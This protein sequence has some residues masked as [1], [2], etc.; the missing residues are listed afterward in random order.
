M[1]KPKRH[2]TNARQMI[3]HWENADGKIWAMQ[4]R[5]KGDIGEI[6]LS[7]PYETIPEN[8]SVRNK[9][10]KDDIEKWMAN[11][12]E[13]PMASLWSKMNED[14]IKGISNDDRRIVARYILVQSIRTAGMKAIFNRLIEEQIEEHTDAHG[15][16]MPLY[17]IY[18]SGDREGAWFDYYERAEMNWSDDG[19]A[20]QDLL[21]PTDA[22]ERESR[23]L[24]NSTWI[25]WR[26]DGINEFITSDEPVLFERGALHGIGNYEVSLMAIDPMRMLMICRKGNGYNY[27]EMMRHDDVHHFNL[28]IC[29]QSNQIIARE[30]NVLALYSSAMQ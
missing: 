18:H 2:H 11:E 22:F 27:L 21:G 23:V 30:R 4:R 20:W 3:C 19:E 6:A 17:E 5:R 1:N 15:N 12:I 26:S 29:A 8:V 24:A 16:L 13:S 10:Y 9:F 28:R 7:V 14:K 25:L